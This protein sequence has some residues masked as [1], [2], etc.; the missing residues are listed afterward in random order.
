MSNYKLKEKKPIYQ[1]TKNP[2]KK[3]NHKGK[4]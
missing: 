3:R 1:T 4:Q 2:I